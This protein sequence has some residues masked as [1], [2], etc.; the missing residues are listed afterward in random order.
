MKTR[1]ALLWVEFFF[2]LYAWAVI[3]FILLMIVPV[4]ESFFENVFRK[5]HGALPLSFTFVVQISHF[6]LSWWPAIALIGI[7]ALTCLHFWRLRQKTEEDGRTSLVW[8]R[9]IP[10]GVIVFGIFSFLFIMCALNIQIRPIGNVI[11]R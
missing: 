11:H 8:D 7:S 10:T 5:F 9:I 3:F 2:A 6:I 1:R 4:H